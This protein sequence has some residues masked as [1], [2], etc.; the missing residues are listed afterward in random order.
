[1][2]SYLN[3]GEDDNDEEDDDGKSGGIDKNYPSKW[4]MDFCA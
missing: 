2:R 4:Y 3:L 1:M